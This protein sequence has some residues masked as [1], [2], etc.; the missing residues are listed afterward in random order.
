MGLLLS[1][2]LAQG[3]PVGFLTQALPAILRKN[4]VSLAAIGGFGLLMAP[5]ALKFLWAPVVDRYFSPQWGQSRS[6]IIPT[7]CLT[8]LLLLVISFLEPSA[9]ASPVIL[10][11]FFIV[12]FLINLMGA[13]QDIATDG[14]AVRLLHKQQQRW[15]NA[16]QVLGSRL[17]FIFGGGAVLL[18]LDLWSWQLVFLLLTGFVLLNS[19][20]ILFF[21]EPVWPQ[22]IQVDV[23]P[24]AASKLS[25]SRPAFTL[26]KWRKFFAVEF[27][28]FWHSPQM[29]AWLLV[30]LTFKLGDSLSGAMVK[31][32]MVDMGFSLGNIGLMASMLGSV[33]SVLGALLAAWW[34]KYMARSTALWWF[35]LLQILSFLLYA[36]LAWQFEYSHIVI[37]WQVYSVN[38]IEQFA[39]AMALVAMLTLIMDYSRKQQAGSDFTFQVSVLAV[40][41]GG[42]HIVSGIVAEYWGYSI[43]FGFCVLLAVLCL[44]PIFRWKRL[45]ITD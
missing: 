20:P 21:R 27:A 19:L 25:L 45:E 28:Y 32:M 24:K 2:Y 11:S 36:I 8:I 9:L 12:L 31:P 35:N 43:H 39:G 6:W 42:V 30:L 41:G 23:S 29:R 5:W 44:W 4:N 26:K 18:L 37:A 38:A 15:G 22:Q 14:L 10:L 17:G 13:T 34:M 16:V 7:Q 40:T 1:L 33:A 3:L